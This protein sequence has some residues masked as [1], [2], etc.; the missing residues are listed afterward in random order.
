MVGTVPRRATG[1]RMRTGQTLLVAVVTITALTAAGPTGSASPVTD[2]PDDASVSR[3]SAGHSAGAGLS[4]DR[5]LA[6]VEAR[7]GE[8]R[9]ADVALATLDILDA[10]PGFRSILVDEERGEATAELADAP[11][12]SG[13]EF[14]GDLDGDGLT[15][16]VTGLRH[17]DD[18]TPAA[19]L[20]GSRGS[21]GTTLWSVEIDVPAEADWWPYVIPDVTGD[22]IAD[23]L[24]TS[25]AGS[26]WSRSS[27]GSDGCQHE[28]GSDLTADWTIRSGSDGA[29][30]G[31]RRVDGWSSALYEDRSS[32]ELTSSRKSHRQQYRTH[33]S[34]TWPTVVGDQDGD[35]DADLL[36]VGLSAAFEYATERNAGPAGL[37]SERS[38]RAVREG[39]IDARIA[40]A[41]G[42]EIG[43]LTGDIAAGTGWVQPLGEPA[44]P[45]AFLINVERDAVY[46]QRCSS[47]PLG[48]RCET[49]TIHAPDE[50][51]VLEA[52][53]FDERFRV[54]EPGIH[55]WAWP[56]VTG[57]GVADIV[58]FDGVR[59]GADGTTWAPLEGREVWEH[60]GETAAGRPVVLSG[61]WDVE[62]VACGT[63]QTADVTTLELARLDGTSGDELAVS[64]HEHRGACGE[65]SW[66][67]VTVSPVADHDGDGVVDLAVLVERDGGSWHDVSE[68]VSGL[69][70]RITGPLA[71][72]PHP[73]GDVDGDGVEDLKLYDRE[74]GEVVVGMPRGDILWRLGTDG[75]LWQTADVD[76]DGTAEALVSRRRHEDDGDGTASVTT[77]FELVTGRDGAVRWR[78]TPRTSTYAYLTS[79]S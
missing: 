36:W 61:S 79:P 2:V 58:T 44:E 47:E 8:G 37:W 20:T 18:G 9:P 10:T 27:C 39:T 72:V 6:M 60:L 45:A 54:R 71:G 38:E 25:Y 13:V 31:S 11:E 43:H 5:V 70:G 12:A 55:G 24:E 26:D 73:I 29:V 62:A 69:G 57:D 33:R 63:M 21:D 34:P 66:S 59:S 41:D 48:S 49:S 67:P 52:V 7:L 16:V 3:T 50:L 15:D 68:V 46:E 56:D 40:D 28:H 1:D 32:A 77:W 75:A 64:R 14:A 17:A 19:R 42:T 22:D 4:R 53:T 65:S 76:G 30:I 74:G 78:T 35:G 23:V 51:R